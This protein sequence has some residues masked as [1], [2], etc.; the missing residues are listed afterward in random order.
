MKKTHFIVGKFGNHLTKWGCKTHK[1]VVTSVWFMSF[2]SC[3]VK[4]FS[5]KN[6]SVF[7]ANVLYKVKNVLKYFSVINHDV[8]IYPFCPF[9]S[10]ICV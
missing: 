10:T 9:N 6:L 5:Q 2:I 7:H 3:C 8:V 4:T 1:C